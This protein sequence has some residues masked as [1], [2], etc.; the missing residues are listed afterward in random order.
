M[1]EIWEDLKKCKGI[2]L[3]SWFGRLNVLKIHF[4]PNLT[5]ESMHNRSKSKWYFFSVEIKELILN[6]LENANNLE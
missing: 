6:L 5:I 2:I 3:C 1:R 4:S